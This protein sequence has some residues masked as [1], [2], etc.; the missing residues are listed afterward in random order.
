MQLIIFKFCSQNT[1]LL[2]NDKRD[3]YMFVLLL[4]LIKSHSFLIA[5]FYRM[6]I[7]GIELHLYRIEREG[8]LLRNMF[9]IIIF[10]FFIHKIQILTIKNIFYN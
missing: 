6:L 1:Y 4:N 5:S 2:K 9:S 7:Y 8:I 10:I 3:I